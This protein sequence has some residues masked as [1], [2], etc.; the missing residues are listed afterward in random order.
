MASHAVPVST[1]LTEMQEHLLR[2][3]CQSAIN[4]IRYVLSCYEGFDQLEISVKDDGTAHITLTSPLRGDD[5]EKYIHE[6]LDS[7]GD[8]TGY[9]YARDGG[10]K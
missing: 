8:W 3:S 5:F 6:T 1:H 4:Y 10:A 2:K 9:A 7:D